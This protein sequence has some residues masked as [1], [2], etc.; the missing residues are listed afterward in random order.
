VLP[1]E[2]VSVCFSIYPDLGADGDPLD[3]RGIDGRPASAQ[4]GSQ[5]VRMQS[6]SIN[7][8]ILRMG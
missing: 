5:S 2:D 7:G 6:V 1:E 8:L 4:S 3:I